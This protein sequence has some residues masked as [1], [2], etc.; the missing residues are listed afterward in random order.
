MFHK[1]WRKHGWTI[2]VISCCSSVEAL[3]T[4]EG[5]PELKHKLS[6]TPSICCSFD[7]CTKRNC[8]SLDL[9]KSG[10][11]LYF[12][13]SRVRSIISALFA[14]QESKGLVST[15]QKQPRPPPRPATCALSQDKSGRVGK[16][17]PAASVLVGQTNAPWAKFCIHQKLTCQPKCFCYI[18]ISVIS[19]EVIQLPEIIDDITSEPAIW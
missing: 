13:G 7:S 11:F 14:H 8:R 9:V 10:G 6:C 16:G 15:K 4:F 19:R 18:I 17:A 3:M 5:N 2:L 1:Q 12:G